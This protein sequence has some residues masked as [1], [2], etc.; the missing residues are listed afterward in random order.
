M[1]AAHG[2]RPRAAFAPMGP[3][4]RIAERIE[5]EPRGPIVAGRQP[6]T[7]LA[8]PVTSPAAAAG[9][10]ILA[11]PTPSSAG[12]PMTALVISAY[13]AI[14]AAAAR[15]WSLAWS[16]GSATCRPASRCASGSPRSRDSEQV[17]IDPDGIMRAEQARHD[18]PPRRP[19][20]H[21]A[22]RRRAAIANTTRRDG[23]AAPF[24]SGWLEAD[25]PV[26][27]AVDH[28]LASLGELSEPG[29]GGILGGAIRDGDAVFA[30]SSMP[31]RDLEAS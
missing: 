1:C 28:R 10:P 9:Y 3:P 20:G 21:R 16:F 17:V 24:A 8:E 6:D 2:H 25:R 14:A 30:A 27:E 5:G 15:T 12:A 18:D 31:V 4:D 26:R 11:E 7:R 22:R 23:V 19:R 29:S 13:D